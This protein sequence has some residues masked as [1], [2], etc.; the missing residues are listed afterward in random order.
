MA[1]QPTL[2]D[3]SKRA[4]VSVATVS[5]VLS[6][7]AAVKS[8]KSA[9]VLAAVESLNYRSLRNST[10]GESKRPS[11]EVGQVAVVLLGQ[12]VLTNYSSDFAATLQAAS[13]A[14][15]AAGRSMLIV[16]VK[17]GENIPEALLGDDLDGLLI[18]GSDADE[19]V[20][21]QLPDRPVVWLTS[22]RGKNQN[23]AALAGNEYVGQLA[24][25]YLLELGCRRLACL[26]IA[27]ENPANETRRR[28]FAFTASQA[29]VEVRQIDGLK[30]LPPDS[31][32][33]GWQKIEAAARGMVDRLVAS[34]PTVDGLFVSNPLVLGPI[35]QAL[36]SHGIEPETDLRII[37]SGHHEP[38]LASLSPRPASIDL[39]GQLIGRCAV[40]HL[41]SLIEKPEGSMP[42]D[43][44]I[45]PTLQ[46]PALDSL[47]G[48]R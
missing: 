2:I 26:D 5:R 3:V 8:D 25:D 43:L 45:R 32:P 10:R 46:R 4:G 31:D 40:Q 12:D 29:G 6:G 39:R 18:A 19:A 13:E 41:L 42:V 23:T 17:P 24:A 20:I 33:E 47:E 15:S 22:H 35:Y 14:L 9:R 21:G 38:L 48:N 7:S 1:D 44:M 30:T 37:T 34:G 11:R 36:R 16:N 27:A 28:F